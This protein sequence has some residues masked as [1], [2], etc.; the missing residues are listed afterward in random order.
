[1]KKVVTLTL[2]AA[3]LMFGAVFHGVIT[4]TGCPKGDHTK[5]N[6]GKDPQCVVACVKAGAK[7]MLYNGKDGYIL[8]DQ[9]SPAAFAA[10]KVIV[11]GTLDPKHDTIQVTSIQPAK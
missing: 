11:T 6:M 10:R 8:S 1:M 3:S 2:A 5:M 7:Y 9:K 4:D